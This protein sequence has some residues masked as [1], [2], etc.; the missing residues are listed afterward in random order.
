MVSIVSKEYLLPLIM[1]W[2]PEALGVAG[3]EHH[4]VIGCSRDPA[5]RLLAAQDG[6]NCELMG[7]GIVVK[8]RG[9]LE[10]ERHV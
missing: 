6:A 5:R 8:R 2:V 3:R 10:E 9:V 1:N 4:P 7:G